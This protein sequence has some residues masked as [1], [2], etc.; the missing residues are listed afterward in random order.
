VLPLDGHD[1]LEALPTLESAVLECKK[2]SVDTPEVR[3]ALDLLEPHIQREWL[4]PQFRHLL[5]ASEK[6]AIRGKVNSSTFE[7]IRESLRELIGKQMGALG[8]QFTA[9]H[10]MKVKDEI[11]RF[12]KEYCKLHDRSDIGTTLTKES[13]LGVHPSAFRTDQFLE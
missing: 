13:S 8:R 3:E 1:R 6:T 11:E 9:T 10:D 7:G 4:I 2:R 5:E 12:A